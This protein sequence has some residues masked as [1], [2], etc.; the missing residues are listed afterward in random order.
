MK[1]T[2]EPTSSSD[3]KVPTTKRN[4][5]NGYGGGNQRYARN[6][7]NNSNNTNY[8]DSSRKNNKY[9]PRPSVIVTKKRFTM[10]NLQSFPSPRSN[11]SSDGSAG[12]DF[13]GSVSFNKTTGLKAPLTGS[14]RHPIGPMRDKRFDRFRG[15]GDMDL[16][17]LGE[18]LFFYF[19]FHIYLCIYVNLSKLIVEM[20]NLILNAVAFDDNVHLGTAS[21]IPTL[22]RGVSCVAMRY[23]SD[24]W[25][26]DCGEASQL[27]IQQSNIRPSKIKKLFISHTH[28]WWWDINVVVLIN[29]NKNYSK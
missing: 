16:T 5:T 26:F 2:T 8:N 29:H 14:L 11:E 21:C 27:Q 20:K 23:S 12:F 22:T 13:S 6:H 18:F 15:G 10:Q 1:P 24:I 19:R 25:L 4:V 9:E 17:F 3:F 7:Q 28:G